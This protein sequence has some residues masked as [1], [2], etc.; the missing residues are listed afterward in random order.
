MKATTNSYNQDNY[1]I[2]G[3]Y[4][5]VSICDRKIIRDEFIERM[6]EER[7]LG[8]EKTTNEDLS[9]KFDKDPQTFGDYQQFITME[10]ACRVISNYSDDEIDSLCYYDED[11]ERFTSVS[12]M[13]WINGSKK[14]V[15][16]IDYIEAI[17]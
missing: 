10:E 4:N 2:V 17:K 13:V 3:G 6:I 12:I 9:N 7:G 16:L 5:S 11:L 15:E 1:L 8:D 14:V